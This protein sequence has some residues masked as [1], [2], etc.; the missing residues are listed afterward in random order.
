MNVTSMRRL[1]KT[2]AAR[3][4]G[5]TL[6]ELLV[7]IAII[8][9]LASLLIPAVQAAREAARKSQCKNNLRQIGIGLHAFAS[10]DPQDRL[11]T[12]AYDAKR[13]G[14]PDTYGWVADLVTINAGR[15]HELRC[16]SSTVRGI[17]KLN[18]LIGLNTSGL[19]SA[20]PER[21]N[22]GR[23]G[24]NWPDASGAATAANSAARAA[25]IAEFVRDGY[26]TNYASSW[27]MVRSGPH[28]VNS[29]TGNNVMIDPLSGGGPDMKDF[30]NTLGP[31][32]R[33][34]LETGS[35]P[36]SNVPMMGDA[37]P[38]D[39]NEAVLGF[40]LITP[41][42]VQID[43]G[44]VT[45]ARLGETFNDGP[46]YWDASTGRINLVLNQIPV[47]STIPRQVPNQGVSVTQA[48]EASFAS[49]VPMDAAN[50][51]KLVLQDTRD[52]FAVH[53]NT[54]NVLMADGSVKELIDLNGD[55]F[56]NPGFPVDDVTF[57]KADLA[58]RVGYTD[59]TCEINSFDIYS[60][61]MLNSKIYT[62]GKFE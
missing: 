50:G 1:A 25:Q 17:E 10:G 13:D 59:G 6:I 26:N 5:F 54:A 3:R 11:T 53:G 52:W 56:F 40:T 61:I 21:L 14:C 55:G 60:G 39:V 20:P 62:K 43:S 15:A 46:A 29:A 41:D 35:I 30:R 19:N 45:G 12:G 49:S 24:K 47:I 8:A 51:S 32:T 48:N 16:P 28:V 4:S 58:D 2:R 57:T 34:F 33:R 7:V 9:I 31:L 27:F 23:C 38:G 18:D 37:A 36:A 22:K 42:G 44:L